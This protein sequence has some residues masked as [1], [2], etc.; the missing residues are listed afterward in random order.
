[1]PAPANLIH[2]TSTT[3]GTGNLTVTAVNGKVRFSDSTYG[4]GTG[5][6]DAFWYFISNQS[7]AEWEIGTGHMSDADTLVRDTILFSSNSNNAVNFSAGTKDVTNDVPAGY[8]VRNEGSTVTD[9]HLAAFSG[10]TGRL[11][12]SGGSKVVAAVGAGALSSQATLDISLGSSDMYEIDLINLSPVTDNVGLYARFSQ[13]S[14]F[15]SGLSDYRWGYLQSGTQSDDAADSEIEMLNGQGNQAT[16]LTTITV[17]IYRPSASSFY[18]SMRWTGIEGHS[19]NRN[20]PT[21]GGGTLIANTDAIDGI[22]F[23]FSSGN[24]SSGYYAVRSYSFT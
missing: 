18:K 8:Q 9:G 2:E 13:S 3:T 15:L 6:S 10:A 22:R 16:E 4:F 24:I 11:I 20:F 12:T 19:A 21:T 5:G 7:A 1:M 17:R 23:L 14:S